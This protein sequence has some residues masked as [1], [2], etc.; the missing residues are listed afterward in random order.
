MRILIPSPLQ[1]YTAQQRQVE[2]EGNS[3]KEVLQTLDSEFPGIRFRMINEHDRIRKHIRIF[4]N[5]QPVD[6]LDIAVKSS[7]EVQIICALSGG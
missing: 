1:S 5:K 6:N 2:A 4:V 3:L 7:D